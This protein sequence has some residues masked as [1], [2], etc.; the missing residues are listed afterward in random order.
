MNMT[1]TFKFNVINFEIKLVVNRFTVWSQ[2]LSATG[3]RLPSLM[4]GLSLIL[5][6]SLSAHTLGNPNLEHGVRI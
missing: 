2:S 6:T 3:L 5:W 1:I 4:T